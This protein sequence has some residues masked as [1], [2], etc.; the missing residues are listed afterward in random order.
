MIYKDNES[1][2]LVIFKLNNR[3]SKQDI[4]IICMWLSF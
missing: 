3:P 4:I 1:I 2:T